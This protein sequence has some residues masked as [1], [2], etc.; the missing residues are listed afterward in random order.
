MKTF[1]ICGPMIGSGNLWNGSGVCRDLVAGP[2]PAQ[3]PARA[4]GRV[5]GRTP[6]GQACLAGSIEALRSAH[7]VYQHNTHLGL[8][9]VC[10]FYLWRSSMHELGF[11][12]GLAAEAPSAHVEDAVTVW[13]AYS[14]FTALIKHGSC[15]QESL[16]GNVM[17]LRYEATHCKH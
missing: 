15:E 7:V 10:T 16:T 12:P 6:Q 17:K 11:S 14:S 8:T 2:S 13:S 3:L 9:Q 5:R 4:A 1:Y